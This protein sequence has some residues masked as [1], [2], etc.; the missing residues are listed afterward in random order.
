MPT[1]GVIGIAELNHSD[2]KTAEVDIYVQVPPNELPETK[3]SNVTFK[4]S[5]AE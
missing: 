5:L 2:K 4:S 3:K 1:A